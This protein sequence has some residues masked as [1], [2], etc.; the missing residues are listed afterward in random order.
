[1]QLAVL[2]CG[3]F[4][5]FFRYFLRQDPVFSTICFVGEGLQ[6]CVAWGVPSADV[7]PAVTRSRCKQRVVFAVFK[8]LCG[9]DVCRCPFLLL[10]FQ[11]I[12]QTPVDDEQS[13]EE[14][15]QRSLQCN[16]IFFMSSC[17]KLF[18]HCTTNCF[19][20]YQ[21]DMRHFFCLSKKPSTCPS[22]TPFHPRFVLAGA[23]SPYRRVPQPDDVLLG[24]TCHCLS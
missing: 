15:D 21:S 23:R 14:D 22:L 8:T 19:P 12:S 2:C 13:E 1:M 10:P 16:F 4:D 7:L 9:D 5:L 3:D 6:A 24:P 11:C 17:V 20:W 18:F